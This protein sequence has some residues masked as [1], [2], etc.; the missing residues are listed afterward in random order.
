MNKIIAIIVTYNGMRW[1][2]KCLSNI[3]ESSVYCRILII[4]N[5]S[6]DKTIDFIKSKYPTIN[7][8]ENSSN[9]G[10]GQANNIGIKH[11][12]KGKADYV[13]LINQDVYIEKNTIKSLV[14]VHQSNHNYGILSPIHLNGR[15]VDLDHNFVNYTQYNTFNE[16]REIY[17]NNNKII[18]TKFVNAAMWLIPIDCVKIIGGF[19]SL[20]FH[21]GED[22]DYCNRVTYHGFKIGVVP[23]CTIKHDRE[24]KINTNLMVRSNLVYTVGL[25]HLTNLNS[26][27]F[28]NYLTWTF[29]SIKKVVKLFIKGEFEDIKIE[30][31]NFVKLYS[32]RNKIIRSR[33]INKINNCEN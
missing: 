18:E 29:R 12:L 32:M 22:R 25:A 13:V 6:T 7:I 17:K 14:K 5:N 11:A 24:V 33:K 26:S 30:L 2:K 27:L 19:D 3:Q 1:I 8:V 20:F 15:G 23:L 10:F 31:L 16:I 21:Y 28:F 9:I 4:D